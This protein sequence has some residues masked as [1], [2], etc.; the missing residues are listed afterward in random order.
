MQSAELSSDGRR[1][2]GHNPPRTNPTT[3]VSTG[4]IHAPKE[5]RTYRTNPTDEKPLMKNT[6]VGP[7]SFYT[8]VT[9]TANTT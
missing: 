7:T 3:P 1:M 5:P 4:H 8:H 9:H 2:E 6:Y